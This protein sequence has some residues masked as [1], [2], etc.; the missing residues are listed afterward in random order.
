MNI[1]L[2]GS[3]GLA[4][5]ASLVVAIDAWSETFHAGFVAVAL[6]GLLLLHAM[7]FPRIVVARETVIYA[8][9]VAYMLLELAWT[10][11]RFL[12]LNTLFPAFNVVVIQLIFGSLLAMHDRRAVLAGALVGFL[13]GAV[14]YTSASGFPFRFPADFPYNAVAS[15]YLYGVLVALLFAAVALR[16]LVPLA[17]AA[18]AAVHV[19][20]TTSIKTNLGIAVGALAV[21]VLYFSYVWRQ[22]WRHA[23]VILAAACALAIAIATNPVAVEAMTRGADRVA[24]GLR[25][26]ESREG[27]AGYGAFEKR[28]TW[29]REGL[30]GWASN[31]V[32]GHGV[33]AFRARF[34]ITSHAS[35]VDLLYNSG[36]IGACLFYGMLASLLL[37][38]RRPHRD[39]PR[40]IPLVVAGGTA[41]Y[42]FMSFFGTIHYLL[43]LGAFVALSAGLLRR[44]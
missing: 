40:G 8:V 35:S 23:L 13:L 15:L 28:A 21:S 36:I 9:F 43:T 25:I 11:D 38:L 26:L 42:T 5:A 22:F 10:R 27:L 3:F 31:P 20:A 19:V 39:L 18:I 14:A 44:A 34:G 37:R 17:I 1:G 4:A 7:R 32:F 16:K 41:C 33:E 24:L 30:R 6:V 12:A 2:L 29:Q